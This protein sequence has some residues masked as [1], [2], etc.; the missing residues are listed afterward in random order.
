MSSMILPPM[1]LPLSAGIQ[2][3]PEGGK[4]IEGRIMGSGGINSPRR[5][6]SPLKLK[7]RH[8]PT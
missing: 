8:P 2:G 7:L 4:I 5:R 1:I 6:W 3:Q